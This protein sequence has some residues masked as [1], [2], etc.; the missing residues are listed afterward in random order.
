MA[1]LLYHLHV[2]LH[3]F[4]Y[5]LRLDAVALLLEVGHLLHQIVLYLTDGN[6]RLFL[7]GHKEV[8]GVELVF[9][10]A[11]QSVEGH[12]VHLLEGVDLIVPERYAQ[13]HLAIGHRN[14]DGITLH[15]EVA[16]LQIHVV[17]HVECR[18]QIP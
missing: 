3:A 5:S 14:V 17:A 4:L 7:R 1:Q 15:A 6:V 2:V 9:L 13:H 8:G 16:T 18:Y 10:E 12:S 11:C